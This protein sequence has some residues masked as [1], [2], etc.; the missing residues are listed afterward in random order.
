MLWTFVLCC[1]IIGFHALDSFHPSNCQ[2][3]G[4]GRKHLAFTRK[5]EVPLWLQCVFTSL[6]KLWYFLAEIMLVI[7]VFGFHV[8]RLCPACGDG[9]VFATLLPNPRIQRE[10]VE[11]W[12]TKSSAKHVV[13][14]RQGQT[15]E[16]VGHHNLSEEAQGIWIDKDTV[17]PKF[18]P[19]SGD[20]MIGGSWLRWVVTVWTERGRNKGR[21]PHQQICQGW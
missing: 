7:T 20:H 1:K 8:N 4:F 19:W 3:Q 6:L 21:V 11:C 5:G 18:S 15:W 13:E 16:R 9:K 12:V 2:G 17:L 14:N 10:C